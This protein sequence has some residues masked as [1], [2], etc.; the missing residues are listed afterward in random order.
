MRGTSS[1]LSEIGARVEVMRRAAGTQGKQLL[2]PLLMLGTMERVGS[3]W[4]S[5][6]LRV[7]MDQHNEPLR[8]QLAADHPLSPLNPDAVGLAEAGQLLT[9]YGRHWLVAFAV[10]KYA[11]VRQ[12]VKETNLFLT[13]PNALALFPDAPVAVLTRSPLGVASSFARGNLFERWDYR[14]RYQQM[15][16]AT[17]RPDAPLAGAAPLVPDDDPAD[18]VALARLQVLNTLLVA[19]ALASRPSGGEV[20]CVPYE[21][22]VHNPEAGWHA[23]ARLLPEL[24][25]ASRPSPSCTVAAPPARAEDT[26]VTTVPKVALTAYLSPRQAELVRGAT[27]AALASARSLFPTHIAAQ[28]GE[29][30]AGDHLYELTPPTRRPRRAQ[31]CPASTRQSDVQYVPRDGLRWRNLL[32]SNAEYARFLN[33]LADH[34]LDNTSGGAYL[35]CCEMPH[36]RGGRLHRDL[37]GRW[38]VSPGFDN[39]PAC[40]VTWIG[41]AAFAARHGARL[42][43]LA[44]M[45]GLMF[46]AQVTN[47]DY[48]VG[49]TVAV[50]QDDMPAGAIHHLL[51]NVQVW[52]ADGPDPADGP[53]SRWL[54]GAAW[55]TPSAW[56]E[57]IRRRHRHLAGSSR[58]VGIRL[59]ADDPDRPMPVDLVAGLLGEWMSGLAERSLP[60]SVLDGRLVEAFTRSQADV[61]LGAHV[62][63]GAG[64]SALRQLDETRG[65]ADRWQVGQWHELDA[66]DRCGVGALGDRAHAAADP[67]GLERQVHDVGVATGQVV[68]H[69]QEPARLHVDACLLAHLP[70]QGVADG[71]ARLDL[72]AGQRPGAASVGVLVQKQNL[73]VLDDDAGDTYLHPGTVPRQAAATAGNARSRVV[74]A[75]GGLGTR[76][77]EWARYLPKEWQPVDGRPGIIHILKEIADLGP[78]QVVIVYHPYYEPF[79]TWARQ[80]LSLDGHHR[81]LRS[82]GRALRGD[83]LPHE[84]ALEW[85]PQRG[86]YGDITSVLNGV[87]HFTGQQ[88]PNVGELWVVFG[89][90]LYPASNPLAQLRQRQAGVAVLARPYRPELAQ[91]RGVIATERG[92]DGCALMVELVEKP[93]LRAAK[94]LEQRYGPDNLMLLEGRARLDDDFLYYARSHL[95]APGSEPRLSLALAA[96]A[97]MRAVH[98]VSTTSEVVDLGT[99]P[100]Q[101]PPTCWD[102]KGRKA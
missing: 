57:V 94:A 48:E 70:H 49:D 85:V 69:V 3:N 23:L 29:W 75:A 37:S 2:P 99:P 76:V 101:L 6:T 11:P 62:G 86:S 47:T 43:R 65:E 14:S 92:V 60:L 63:A 12:V 100:E 50:V 4:L 89:D 81:Y 52:C 59:I 17:R 18:L 83:T 74:I 31:G 39:H 7:L 66:A 71:L 97:Q 84:L 58:G 19:E 102:N 67:G 30:L 25:G 16:Q 64:P 45:A 44:E 13:V 40:W 21:E 10:A 35:L 42:P 1:I 88:A 33:E 26:F 15:V 8:Q 68:A 98:V 36:E 32:V 20:V 77:H 9:P 54:T 53:V 51:G 5:D 78:A 95:C 56:E 28:A 72:P 80:T 46:G 87:D 96:Y 22:A 24:A 73:V 61:G 41:A 90:N 55:N 82:A 91:E 34:G 27:T 93:G 79:V 38:T